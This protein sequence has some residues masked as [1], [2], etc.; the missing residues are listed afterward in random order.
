M[1]DREPPPP[2]EYEWLDEN[3]WNPPP[4]ENLA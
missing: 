3:E 1:C 2:K 4:E